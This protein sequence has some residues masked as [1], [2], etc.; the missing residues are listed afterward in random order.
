MDGANDPSDKKLDTLKKR[1]LQN[2][3]T[4]NDLSK[5]ADARLFLLPL[6]SKLVFLHALRDCGIKFAI[7]DSEGDTEIASLAAAWN[8]P[9]LSS[10][11]DFFI[12]DIKAGYIPLSFVYWTSSRL[13]ASVFY[14]RKLASYFRIRAELIPLL[15]SLAGNDYVSSDALAAFNR[16]LSRVQ[17]ASRFGK[18]EARFASI[19]NMLSELPDSCTQEEAFN[20]ALQIV[21]SPQSRDELRQ[22]VELS[23]QEYN[24]KESNLLEYLE[25]DTVCSSIRTQTGREMEKWVL[26]RLRSGQFSTKCISALTAG[27]CFLRVQ[28]ENCREIS[29][30]RCS[31]WLRQFVYGILNDAE[32]NR[33][34]G[35][36]TTVQ[37]WD[38][39]GMTIK[40]SNVVPY[41]EGVVPSVSLIPYLDAEERSQFLLFSL[42]A[43]TSYIKS[44]PEKF[45]L[46]AASLRYLINNAEPAIE[47]NHLK[48]LLCC[49][50]K[51]EDDLGKHEGKITI[52][53]RSSQPF[54]LRAA[55]SFS[56]WQCVLRDAIHLNFALLEPVPTPCIHKTFI[57]QMVQSLHDELQKG[58]TP[59]ALIPSFR[60][61]RLFHKL[62]IAVTDDLLHKM[63]PQEKQSGQKT[64]KK[65]RYLVKTNIAMSEIEMLENRFAFLCDMGGQQ[66]ENGDDCDE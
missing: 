59:E 16:A 38:R 12:F 21:T 47:M 60:L 33:G 35:N 36:I 14:R 9:V 53:K 31:L 29:A 42:H 13:T 25:K 7:C 61:F 11:S 4:A 64:D 24:I 2:I 50:V 5:S 15:A 46:V 41:L 49:C 57:G 54:N 8:C 6:L 66:S 45:K 34:K 51:L 63:A 26:R 17:T 56:Q 27:K 10:D 62:Y 58:R 52:S 20:C 3:E 48:A 18:K 40:Q 1:A 39:D 30:N 44:L 37:E 19:A 23:L 65:R 32:E 43:D 55:H 22:A 28:V